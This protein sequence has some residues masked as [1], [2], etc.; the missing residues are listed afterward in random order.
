MRQLLLSYARDLDDA[1]PGHEFSIWSMVQLLDFFNEALC[2]IAAQR[3]DMFTELKV[4]PVVKCENYLDVC[5]CV[6]VLDVLGQCDEYGRQVR[7]IPRRKEKATVWSGQKRRVVYTDRIS[8]YE[9]LDKSNL[10]RVYPANLDPQKDLFVLLRCS[11]QPT[12][13]G[14]DDQAPD[15][16]CAFMAAARQWVLYNAKS[17]DGEFSQVMQT[18]AKEHREMFIALMQLTKQADDAFDEK[19]RGLPVRA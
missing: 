16:R 7:A 8:E 6:K 2:L 19:L 17:I 11:V 18:Q 3:P 15:E 1:Y 5:D 14:V 9:L 12:V 13:Y 4:V 10:V